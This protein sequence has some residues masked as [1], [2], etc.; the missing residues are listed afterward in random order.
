MTKG[1]RSPTEVA[2]LAT[3]RPCKGPCFLAVTAGRIGSGFFTPM[4]NRSLPFESTSPFPFQ[5]EVRNLAVISQVPMLGG[6]G[7]G[8]VDNRPLEE[9]LVHA[10]TS[11]LIV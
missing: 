1:G 2:N 11:C 9:A 8:R 7:M 6:I 4:R 5:V 3:A 10:P